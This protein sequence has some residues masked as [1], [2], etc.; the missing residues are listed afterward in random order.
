MKFIFLSRGNFRRWNYSLRNFLE[1]FFDVKLI[2]YCDNFFGVGFILSWI[3][4]VDYK[5]NI[6]FYKY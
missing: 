3:L 1:N 6:I 4:N 2:R 5:V